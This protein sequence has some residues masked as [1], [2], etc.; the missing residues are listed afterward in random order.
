MKA[1][2][3]F[4]CKLSALNVTEVIGDQEPKT[5]NKQFPEAEN[6][7]N[8]ILNEHKLT[9]SP[10]CWLKAPVNWVVIVIP[11]IIVVASYAIVIGYQPS[12]GQTM[13]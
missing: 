7:R 5:C 6:F 4:T 10:D 2:T 13:N 12:F 8:R 3:Q 11:V 9:C 1:L